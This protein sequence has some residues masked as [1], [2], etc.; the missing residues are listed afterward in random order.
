[1]PLSPLGRPGL[2][3]P[4]WSVSGLADYVAV[5]QHNATPTRVAVA[6]F[7]LLHGN[8]A[9]VTSLFATQCLE[10]VLHSQTDDRY[11]LRARTIATTRRYGLK[12]PRQARL[13]VEMVQIVQARGR[14]RRPHS[15]AYLG[16]PYG[17]EDEAGRRARGW[18]KKAWSGSDWLSAPR[19]ASRH[20]AA[21]IRRPS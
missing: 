12:N 13:A 6:R 20:R 16:W 3:T 2:P 10:T 5:K 19:P 17:N 8:N 9:T 1:M 4:R 21:G 15:E 11:G 7:T 14:A 18:Q